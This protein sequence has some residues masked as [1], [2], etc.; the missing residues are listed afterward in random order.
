MSVDLARWRQLEGRRVR[1]EL[2]DG[3]RLD[4]CLL[5]SAGRGPVKTCWL[6]AGGDDLFVVHADV[7]DVVDDGTA[8]TWR[9]STGGMT[10]APP[11][12]DVRAAA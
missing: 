1:L 2:H 5:I 4:G 7:I 8:T 3:T 10:C 11:R 9:L 6:L 12:W